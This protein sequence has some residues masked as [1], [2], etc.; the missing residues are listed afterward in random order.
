MISSRV[1]SAQRTGRLQAFNQRGKVIISSFRPI[2]KHVSRQANDP[3]Q[4]QQSGPCSYSN[5]DSFKNVPKRQ[6]PGRPREG[7]AAGPHAIP[8]DAESVAEGH[9]SE[10]PPSHSTVLR[11][12]PAQCHFGA[13]LRSL[14]SVR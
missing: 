1:T 10:K 7:S 8:G 13:E 5:L 14:R 3:G 4:V 2:R 6:V 9:H 12:T 11:A